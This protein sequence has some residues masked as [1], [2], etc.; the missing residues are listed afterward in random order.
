MN[1]HMMH[2]R[3]QTYN[4]CMTK[5]SNFPYTDTYSSMCHN[6]NSKHNIHYIPYFNTPRL[7]N[8]I[9]NNGHYTTNIPTDPNTVTTIDIKTNMCHIHTSIVSRHLDTITKYWGGSCMYSDKDGQMVWAHGRVCLPF[10]RGNERG[11]C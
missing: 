4:I 3:T 8:T 10:G 1:C 9:F 7:K 2:T 6:T 5:H 11:W